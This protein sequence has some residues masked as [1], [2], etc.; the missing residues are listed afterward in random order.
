MKN[1]IILLILFLSSC[2]Y[3]FN[4]LIE[5]LPGQFNLLLDRKNIDEIINNTNYN[6]EIRNKL[7]I[8]KEIKLFAVNR[9]DLKDNNN[10]NTYK[11]ISNN[12]LLYVL[13]ACP[14]FSLSPLS[15]NFPI[16]GKVPY[17]GFFNISNALKNAIE[18]SNKGFDVSIRKVIAYSMLNFYPD[19][20]Y[21]TILNYDISDLAEIIIHEMVHSTIWFNNYPEFN[22][23]LAS[24]IGIEGAILFIKEKFGENNSLIN[25]IYNSKHD[26]KLFSTYINEIISNLTLLYEN[27]TIDTNTK[28]KLKQEYI[29]YFNELFTNKYLPKMKTSNYSRWTN[30]VINNAIIATINVYEKDLSLFYKVYEKNND[31]NSIIKYA[32]YAKN[33]KIDPIKYFNIL[34]TNYVE[35]K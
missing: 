35:V 31:L 2:F 13:T 14:Q 20:V 28:L 11:E 4:Y 8:I 22:E 26:Q 32:I 25:E 23:N 10:Y 7:K 33:K 6:L 27:T 5:Q 18:L 17:L 19:P 21:S 3:E 9:L 24:F 30:V 34:I 1:I 15:W 16:V 12:C 29:K